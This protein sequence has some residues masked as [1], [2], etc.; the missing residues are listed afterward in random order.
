MEYKEVLVESL[1]ETDAVCT[2]QMDS[3]PEGRVEMT[4]EKKKKDT[5]ILILSN[6]CHI[7]IKLFGYAPYHAC[8]RVVSLMSFHI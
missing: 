7:W 3:I 6:I 4:N 8:I 1:L 2:V 5:Q